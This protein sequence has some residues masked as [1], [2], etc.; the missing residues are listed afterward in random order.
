MFFL[1]KCH[2]TKPVSALCT[3][4]APRKKAKVLA[5]EYNSRLLRVYGA[6]EEKPPT[7]QDLKF[8]VANHLEKSMAGY[9]SRADWAETE[10]L[11]G[12]HPTPSDFGGKL[13]S[14]SWLRRHYPNPLGPDQPIR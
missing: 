2:L 12:E 1:P 5:F 13:H 10:V 6:S 14:D 11:A 7:L 3:S 9:L 8:W 4:V